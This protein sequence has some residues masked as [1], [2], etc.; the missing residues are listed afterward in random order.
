MNHLFEKGKIKE[1][2]A[3]H[4]EQLNGELHRQI[5]GAK[6]EIKIFMNASE[7]IKDMDLDKVSV[8]YL[9]Q[10]LRSVLQELER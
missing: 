9:Q 10:A 2:T 5:N 4:Q 1:L 6:R 3:K 8:E 7:R